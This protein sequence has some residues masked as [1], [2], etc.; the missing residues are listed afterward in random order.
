MN[1]GEHRWWRS[2]GPAPDSVRNH[3]ALK[4]LNLDFANMGYPSIRPSPLV[5]KTL[6]FLGDSG[7]LSGDPGGNMLRAYSKKSGAVVAEIELPSKSTGA[8][9]TYSH[10]GKQYV[11]VAVATR[12]HPAELVALT[13]SD[14]SP[15]PVAVTDTRPATRTTPSSNRGSITKAMQDQIDNGRKVYG[16]YCTMC[17]GANGEGMPGGAPP[18]SNQTNVDALIDRIKKGGIQMPPMQ[19]MLT[20]QQIR[21]TAL[22]VEREF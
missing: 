14:G 6:L 11:V 20:E 10:R 22:F 18:L 15:K 1:T 2:I 8:P 21:D 13:L 7:A 4:G 9:M 19:T 16:Q 3:P 5:T 12:E 17:H